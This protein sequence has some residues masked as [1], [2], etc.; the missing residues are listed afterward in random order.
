MPKDKNNS[1]IEEYLKERQ[2]ER[3]SIEKEVER[4]IQE[5]LTPEEQEKLNLQK[6]I[7]KLK[8]GLDMEI[9]DYVIQAR[10]FSGLEENRE[11]FIKM[12]AEK[13]QKMPIDKW[14]NII[15]DVRDNLNEEMKKERDAERKYLIGKR[16]EVL[17]DVE[18]KLFLE[19][20]KGEK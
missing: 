12:F 7:E 4:K 9:E 10:E 8:I 5:K 18:N 20:P 1:N 14:Q 13:I 3:K 19:I 17:K 2:L 6:Q 16:L 15:N 11:K